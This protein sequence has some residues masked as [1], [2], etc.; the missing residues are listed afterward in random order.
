MKFF[1]SARYHCHS[2]FKVDYSYQA[3]IFLLITSNW[4]LSGYI[5]L[6]FTHLVFHWYLVF[7]AYHNH[8][9]IFLPLKAACIDLLS[10]KIAYFLPFCHL[11][12]FDLMLS[13][14]AVDYSFHHRCDFKECIMSLVNLH[15]QIGYSYS[16][17]F[18]IIRHQ[19]SY[20]HNRVFLV[21][22]AILIWK[23]ACSPESFFIWILRQLLGECYFEQL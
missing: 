5:P 21:F 4:D 9:V 10:S 15:I 22:F 16:F 14:D 20:T 19:N 1:F 13:E 12:W 17:H 23:T 7:I 8:F 6:H 3:C 11:D 2:N 18:A